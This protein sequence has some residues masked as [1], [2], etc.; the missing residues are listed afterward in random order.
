MKSSVVRARPS[1]NA[2]IE[3]E[4]D[5]MK[6]DTLRVRAH[7]KINLYLNVLGKRDD[8]YHELETIFHSIALHD[9][10]IIRLSDAKKITVR[11]AHP[12]VPNDARNLAYRAARCLSG[13][14][15]GI[16]GV[17]I[18]IY[19]RIP[20]A[21][22][23]AGGSA[24]AAAVL[25]GINQ[26]FGCGF[27]QT[28]LMQM[29]TGLGADVPFC[30]QGGAAFGRGIGEVL[31]PLP[32]LSDTPI[33]LLNPGIAVATANIFKKLHFFLTN[34]EK[35]SIIIE[36]FVK[37]GELVGIGANL[38]NRL[39]MPAFIAHPE[40]AAL[41]SQLSTQADCHGALMTGS[42]ATV[43]GLMQDIAAAERSASRFQNNVAFC[44]TTT[45][46]AVGVRIDS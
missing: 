31:T 5:L 33:L 43:F 16:G 13:A 8:G 10:V 22:G 38:Y 4:Q 37:R 23:L 27:T 19:K 17:A 32:A 3:S 39:E 20:V 42:G 29:G 9:D 44:T 30:L 46:S 28:E 40:I 21:A 2:G 14:V 1:P 7:A 15:G 41:K 6:R 18:D 12:G 25:H 36:T 35:C 45:T 11:C 34:G 24:N 26:L